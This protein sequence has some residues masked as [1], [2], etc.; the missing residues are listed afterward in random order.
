MEQEKESV[1]TD[2]K[3]WEKRGVRERERRSVKR[4]VEA[5]EEEKGEKGK[6]ES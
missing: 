5:E 2:R 6:E 3:R 1:E 4:R